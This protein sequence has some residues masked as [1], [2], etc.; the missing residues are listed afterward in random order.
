VQ[1]IS[2]ICIHGAI[3]SVADGARVTRREGDIARAYGAGAPVAGRA[4]P[5]RSRFCS[6][7][8]AVPSLTSAQ[9]PPTA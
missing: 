4:R 5:G 9:V 6:P 1:A 7:G 2:H 3:Q 8:T